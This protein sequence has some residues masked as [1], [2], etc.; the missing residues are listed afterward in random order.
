[1][2][3][4]V[5]IKTLR[6][7]SYGAIDWNENNPWWVAACLLSIL[8]SKFNIKDSGQRMYFILELS[9]FN[10]DSLYTSGYEIDRIEIY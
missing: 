1:M 10:T 7:F 2:D 5:E 4:L 9:V 6:G 3:C 8:K